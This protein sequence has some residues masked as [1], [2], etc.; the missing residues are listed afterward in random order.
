MNRPTGRVAPGFS[1]KLQILA[2]SLS[3]ESVDIRSGNSGH[4]S[5][6]GSN[7]FQI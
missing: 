5:R 6:Q 2:N 3:L 1:P 7:R 4:E